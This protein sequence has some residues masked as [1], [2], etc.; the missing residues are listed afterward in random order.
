MRN[1]TQSLLHRAPLAPR[2]AELIDLWARNW[3][4]RKMRTMGLRSS[5]VDPTVVEATVEECYI[6]IMRQI[7]QGD[8]VITRRN[9]LHIHTVTPGLDPYFTCIRCYGD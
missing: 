2:E 7:G 8:L 5:L 6:D 3:M 9:G 4:E 1:T